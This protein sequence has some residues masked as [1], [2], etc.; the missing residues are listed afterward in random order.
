MVLK[1]QRGDP[2]K[3]LGRR[4]LLS[5]LIAITVMSAFGVW[6]TYRKEREALALKAE[7]QAR[8][9]DLSE[10]EGQL[11]SDISGLQTDRGKETALREQYAL[12]AA[13][14]HLIVIVDEPAQPPPAASS[15]AFVEWLHK[16]FPWW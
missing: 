10:R 7:A 12:A 5:G 6:N 1:R 2:V 16:T 15:S 8:A 9:A 14:E 3:L 4:F 13:G 11:K